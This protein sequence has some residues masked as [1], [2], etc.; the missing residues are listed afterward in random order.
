[1]F[2]PSVGKIPWRRKWQ[3][4]PVLLP[5]KSHGQRSV[6]QATIHG[7]AKSMAEQLHF[8]SRGSLLGLSG[9]LP[10]SVPSHGFTPLGMPPGR[11][12]HP[13]LTGWLRELIASL[14]DPPVHP[15]CWCGQKS[16]PVDTEGP[17]EPQSAFHPPA[18]QCHTRWS[19][20]LG[21]MSLTP[22]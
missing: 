12:G 8:T 9:H 18:A 10:D 15:C 13:C 1:M 16:V 2:N 20:P 11:I 17:C 6:V 19:S 21:P 4:T 5:W 14:G 3:P 7:V 22:S